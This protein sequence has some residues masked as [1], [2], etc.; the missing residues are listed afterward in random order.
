MSTNRMG[1]TRRQAMLA[2]A[3]LSLSCAVQAQAAD[4]AWNDVVR[5]A[6]AEG[7]INLY[8][9]APLGQ[10]QRLAETFQKQY[11]SIQ[12]NVVRGV[13][14]L[15]ARINAE[16]SGNIDGGDVLLFADPAWFKENTQH[17]LDANGPAAAAYPKQAWSVAGKVPLVTYM[18][19]GMII[20][21]KKM[22]PGGVKSYADLLNPAYKGHIGTR[23]EMT[24]F[25]AGFLDWQ[26]Q[27]FGADYLPKLA[28]QQPKFYQSIV[29]LTQAVA[30]G[31]VWIANTGVPSMT[32]ELIK[33]GAP[34]DYVIT[35]PTFAIPYAV[36][37]I[38]TS[39]RPNAARLMVDFLM[40]EQGQR[41]LNGDN[42]SAS[43]SGVKGALSPKG[44]T[45]VDLAK[46]TPE[47]R[48]EW[49]KKFKQLF[50]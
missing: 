26:E 37:A 35:T 39:R 46:Y 12:V 14:D 25:L 17:L 36:G 40:T 33:Q 32:K 13:T 15:F 24:A 23:G 20:W 10:A 30:S 9:G 34:I 43:P 45:I 38:G 19:H 6:S 29:P 22:V 47:K 50:R 44:L 42:D 7:K 21:N 1:C 48:E 28:A 16:R 2:I 18:P 8:T 31:E 41:A 4:P 5:K 27:A 11:P 3:A 49:R